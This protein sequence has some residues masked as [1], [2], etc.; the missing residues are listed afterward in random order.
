MVVTFAILVFWSL[1]VSADL[2][3]NKCYRFESVNYSGEYMRHRNF[4]LYKESGSGELYVNDSSFKVISAINGKSGLVSLESFNFPG[5]DIRHY[6]Y[7]GKIS[8]CSSTDDRCKDDGS[9][10]VKNALAPG[11]NVSFA[12]YNKNGFYLRHQGGRVRIANQEDSILY[13]ED[14]SW[15]SHEVSCQDSVTS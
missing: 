3:K 14:A 2:E 7:Y 9:W 5:Y 10:T 11:G 12:S 6:H 4:N 8:E 13:K 15:I 1:S